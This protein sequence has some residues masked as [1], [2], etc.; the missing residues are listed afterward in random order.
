VG[1]K[2]AL[3]VAGGD[4]RRMLSDCLTGARYEVLEASAADGPLPS[5]ADVVFLDPGTVEDGALELLARVFEENHTGNVVVVSSPEMIAYALPNGASEYLPKPFASWQ[6]RH[7][8]GRLDHR[9]RLERQL[10]SMR[11]TAP[12]SA[13]LP[14]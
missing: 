6:V 14:R 5:E 12:A 8:I 9:W 2:L 1:R 13:I 10:A 4:V 7:L 3:V 11:P